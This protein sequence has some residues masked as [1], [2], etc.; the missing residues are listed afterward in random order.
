MKTTVEIADDLLRRSQLLAKREGSTLRAVLEE[1][2][3]LV[4]KQRRV[5][6]S[7]PL[8]I[9]TFGQGGLTDEFRDA[10]WEK[11]RATIYGDG[12]HRQ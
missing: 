7:P 10:N 2:L 5:R 1:G 12:T 8:R 11:I 9:P 4:L 6:A 3:R